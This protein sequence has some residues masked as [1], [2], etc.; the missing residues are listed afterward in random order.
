LNFKRW[1]E[2]IVFE[3]HPR[4]N[5]LFLG[6]KAYFRGHD[7]YIGALPINLAITCVGRPTRRIPN[8]F[9]QMQRKSKGQYNSPKEAYPNGVTLAAITVPDRYARPEYDSA[10]DW[11]PSDPKIKHFVSFHDAVTLGVSGLLTGLAF[12]TIFGL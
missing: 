8:Y 9:L 10:D 12:G 11:K 6:E 4:L 2:A 5:S 1:R 7:E 3:G